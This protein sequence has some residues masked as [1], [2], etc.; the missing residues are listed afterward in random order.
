MPD[1]SDIWY[2]VKER[3]IKMFKVIALCKFFGGAAVL[4]LLCWLRW[5]EEW[6]WMTGIGGLVVIAVLGFL[7]VVE[8][9]I[10][11]CAFFSK[12]GWD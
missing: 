1:A 10:N 11:A 8:T 6:H 4:S 2:T 5:G 12:D 3:M 7:F 9:L